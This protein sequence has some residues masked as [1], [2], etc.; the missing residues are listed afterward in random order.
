MEAPQMARVTTYGGERVH[1]WSNTR[2]VQH[3]QLEVD[4]R[5]IA[6]TSIPSD[7]ELFQ[8]IA[9]VWN[10]YLQEHFGDLLP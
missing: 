8:R 3:W 2:T 7:A 9:Q 5:F 6:D 1:E 10:G 4:G